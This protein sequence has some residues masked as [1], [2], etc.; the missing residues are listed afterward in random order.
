MDMQDYNVSK[1]KENSDVTEVYAIVTS[2]DT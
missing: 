1:D 2:M